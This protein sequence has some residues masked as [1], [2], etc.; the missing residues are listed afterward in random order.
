[1]RA[2]A[3]N[4]QVFASDTAR[5]A[6]LATKKN[7]GH[8]QQPQR[9]RT[10]QQKSRDNKEYINVGHI[11]FF[12]HYHQRPLLYDTFGDLQN[13]SVR[14][15]MALSMEMARCGVFGERSASV[16]PR[17]AIHSLGTGLI[18]YR[19][20]IFILTSRRIICHDNRERERERGVM[21][22]HQM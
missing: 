18:W 5:Q 22:G 3:T 13:A 19:I 9:V 20:G 21:C 15:A 11:L 16:T 6:N 12:R 4:S 2:K 8:Q 10:Q 1:M 7:V 17:Q 14:G